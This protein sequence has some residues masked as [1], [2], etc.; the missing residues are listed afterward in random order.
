M[1]NLIMGILIGIGGSWLLFQPDPIPWFSWPLLALGAAS[2]VF[3]FDVLV[4]SFKE[5]E[6]RAA[7]MGF[8]IFGTFGAALILS[9]WSLAF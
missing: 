8:G 5:N 9:G 7:W 1:V 4:G 3:A 2:V 6:T